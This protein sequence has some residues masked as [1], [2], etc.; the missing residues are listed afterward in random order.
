MD[1]PLPNFPGLDLSQPGD[2]AYAVLMRLR[3]QGGYPEH[4]GLRFAASLAICR[5]EFRSDTMLPRSGS[6]SKWVALE[7]VGRV[8]LGSR[9]VGMPNPYPARSVSPGCPGIDVRQQSIPAM[10]LRAH[11][12]AILQP[13]A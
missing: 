2:A 3:F 10:P 12:P 7:T 11:Y 4:R 1:I 5:A 6:N 8:P 9:R 13:L